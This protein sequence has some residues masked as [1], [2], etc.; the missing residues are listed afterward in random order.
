MIKIDLNWLFLVKFG[1][2]GAKWDTHSG[3]TVYEHTWIYIHKDEMGERAELIKALQYWI[4]SPTKNLKKT[5]LLLTKR[6]WIFHPFTVG[7]FAG[8]LY[9]TFCVLETHG[10]FLKN[11]RA[12]LT[13][14]FSVQI[15]PGVHP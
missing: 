13:Q 3:N 2:E 7:D 4:F 1:A 9:L 11:R 5:I 8:R 10:G 15:A 12:S 6:E 14:R